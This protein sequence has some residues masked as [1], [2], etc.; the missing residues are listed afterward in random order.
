MEPDHEPH[1]DT[2][3]DHEDWAVDPED[4]EDFAGEAVDDHFLY[5]E[6]PA[7]AGDFD[8]DEVA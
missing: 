6:A 3:S 2:N 8:G 4:A 1:D 5:H 7:E